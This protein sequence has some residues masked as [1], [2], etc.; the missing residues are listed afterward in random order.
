MKII[1]TIKIIIIVKKNSNNSNNE[2]NNSIK[3]I[4]NRCPKS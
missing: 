2:N 1:I 4:D 3:A